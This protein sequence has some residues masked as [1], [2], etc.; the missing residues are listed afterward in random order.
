MNLLVIPI[1]RNSQKLKF[2]DQIAKKK[3]T[4]KKIRVPDDS[5]K[6]CAFISGL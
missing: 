4:L 5:I 6:Q 3:G 1:G 2:I